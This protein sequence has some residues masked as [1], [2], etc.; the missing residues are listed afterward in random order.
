LADE[1]Q[2]VA[3]VSVPTPISWAD[4]ERDLT[5]WL[6]NEMQDEAF[7]LL[8]MSLRDKV[9]NALIPDIQRDWL[10]PANL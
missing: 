2:P 5:A 1:L 6:G 10:Y 8:Y 3:A 7:D 4:E 9:R